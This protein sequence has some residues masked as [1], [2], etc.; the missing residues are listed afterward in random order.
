MR[1]IGGLEVIGKTQ[2]RLLK[3]AIFAGGLLAF[4]AVA[5][6]LPC[7]PASQLC[8]DFSDPPT[9]DACDCPAGDGGGTAEA[10]I[11]A[12][13]CS[14]DSCSNRQTQQNPVEAQDGMAY[15]H[16][17]QPYI[18][19]K[20]EDTPI[21]WVAARG[22]AVMFHL[23][24]RQRGAIIEDPAIFGVGTNWS[25]SFRAFLCSVT[26]PTYTPSCATT[27]YSIATRLG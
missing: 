19:L 17:S 18:N 1:T 25:C 16:V 4:A 7:N 11:P 15:Y 5:W 13:G 12:M 10:G 26:A 20:I 14:D 8:A 9:C 24:Y 23:S 21:R 2:K 6:A 3:V 22:K 27:L